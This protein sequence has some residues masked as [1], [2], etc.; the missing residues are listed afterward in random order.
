MPAGLGLLERCKLLWNGND[1]GTVSV[2]GGLYFV[3]AGL[4]PL[5]RYRLPSTDIALG[6]ASI[7]GSL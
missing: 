5:E 7:E 2:E 1:P 6:T 4:G 3:P